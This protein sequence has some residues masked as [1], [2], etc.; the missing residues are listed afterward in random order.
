[1]IPPTDQSV[2]EMLTGTDLPANHQVAEMGPRRGKVTVEK[3]AINAV[4]AGALPTYMPVLIA[5][6]KALDAGGAGPIMMSA[7]TGSFAP[8]WIISGPIRNDLHVNSYYGAFSPGEMANSA[9]GRAMRLIVQNMRGVRRGM[10]DMGVLGNPGKFAMV[11]AENEEASP[12]EPLH[13]ERGLN[14]EDSAITYM[15]SQSFRQFMAYG[16]DDNGIL[17]TVAY[18]MSPGSMGSIWF[19]VTPVNA[20]ALASRGWTK[21]SINDFVVRNASAPRK[22]FSRFYTEAD[23]AE[24]RELLPIFAPP[25][26]GQQSSRPQPNQVQVVVCGGMGVWVGV[27]SG[28]QSGTAKIELP[29][30][31]SK[32]VAK[33]KTVV[34]TFAK[35]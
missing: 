29:A 11:I 9:I 12:W 26:G 13:V 22:H 19:V 6:V 2:A 18:N 15:Y 7:S 17:S 21:K 5:A 28:G 3:I 34:P 23:T 10:E 1:V 16:T 30:N 31:W 20:K 32:L 8:V 33:Y 4:M 27:L 24:N 35:Y 14:K 25:P